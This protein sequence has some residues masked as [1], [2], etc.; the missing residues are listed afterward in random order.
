MRVLLINQAYYPDVAATAQHAHDLATH[1]VAHGHDV[2]VIASRS[3][4]GK[5]G[6]TLPRNE[7]IA[8]V[9]V[10]RV[11]RS[12]FGKAGNVGR[13]IDFVLFYVAA[14]WRAFRVTRPD[15]V[16]CFTTPPLIALVGVLLQAAR[17]CRYV[18]WIMDLY[19]DLAV[20]CG[21]LREGGL[22]TRLFDRISLLCIRRADRVVVLGRCMRDRV[23][24]KHADD[25]RV[26]PSRVIHIGVW[27]DQDE[28][29]PIPRESNPYR[30]EWQLGGRFVV[31][32]SGNF[33]IGHDFSTMLG[34]VERLRDDDRVLFAFVGD[35]KRKAEVER[36][37][38]DRKLTN[39][40][41]FGYQPRERLHASL[42]C[43]DVH[44]VTLR[45]GLEGCIVPCKLFGAM[46]AGRPTIFI[47]HPSSEIARV[48]VDHECGVTVRE[49]DVDSLV[50][51]IRGLL[52]D[53]SRATGLGERARA[54]MRD[55]YDRHH[56][57]E[58]WRCLLEEV[59]A[60]TPS[61]A[62][63]L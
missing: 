30:D 28:V 57:C 59:A 21:V 60:K 61:S 47:G 3:L 19:P 42:S 24:G 50:A 41:I 55:A 9:H 33:G 63:E 26:D 5:A 25:P 37:V 53:P 38:R 2:D 35:G 31:M 49:G 46:A 58:A 56:A 12:L 39:V 34:A 32:Y 4:Y 54:A 18:Y 52:D 10:H 43:A 8:G 7:T 15:V 40:V 36:S 13:A 11:A 48:L 22:L 29:R 51:A 14:T 1:L 44:L 45:E 62:E 6:A 17:R 20:T 27:S 23:T 16:V